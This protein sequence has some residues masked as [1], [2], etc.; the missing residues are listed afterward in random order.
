MSGEDIEAPADMPTSREAADAWLRRRA[1]GMVHAHLT[2]REEADFAR[3]VKSMIDHTVHEYGGRFLF[4]LIQNGYDEQ[5]PDRTDG[6][7]SFILDEDELDHGVLYAANTGKGFTTSNVRAIANLGLSDKEIGQGIG[8]KGVGFKSVLQVCGAPEIYSTLPDGA[9]GFCFRFAQPGDIPGLVDD[10]P[11]SI[12]QVLEEMSLYNITVPSEHTPDFVSELWRLG[13]ASVIRL[14]LRQNTREMVA[15]LLD[16]EISGSNVPVL[17]FLRRLAQITVQKKRQGS[18][19]TVVLTRETESVPDLQDGPSCELVSLRGDERYLVFTS[20]VPPDAFAAAVHVSVESN[21]LDSRWEKS[22]SGVEVSIGVPYGAPAAATGRFFT[23]LPLG[24][25]APSPFG[26]H[27]N[28]PFSTNLARTDIDDA[29]PLNHL[30]LSA[31]AELCVDAAAALTAWPECQPESVLDIVCWDSKRVAFLK[32]QAEAKGEPLIERHF[33]PARSPRHWISFNEAWRWPS[34]E[35]SV[36]TASRATKV[37]K[38]DFLP[39]LEPGRARR[40]KDLLEALGHSPDPSGVQLA[41][42]TEAM[43]EDMRAKKRPIA[44]WD[45]AY[46]DI[47]LLFDGQ[48]GT[49]RSRRILLTD[50]GELRPCASSGRAPDNVTSREATPFFP[51][52]RQPVDEEENFDPEVDLDLPKSLQN[53]LFYLHSGLTW[54]VNRQRT[55]ARNFFQVNRLIR[56]FDTRSILEHVRGL[57]AGSRSKAVSR[58]AIRLVFNLSRSAPSNMNLA[59]LGLRVPTLGGRWIPAS[60]ALFSAGWPGTRGEELALIANTPAD[61][62]IELSALTNRLIATPSELPGSADN[63]SAWVDFLKRIGVGDVLPLIEHREARTLYGRSL[64]ASSLSHVPGMP[65]GVAEQWSGQLPTRSNAFYPETPYKQMTSLFWLPGQAD[66]DHLTGKVRQA[67]CRQIL[68]G[69]KEW[70]DE[71]FLTTWERD[72]TG[73][74]DPR[75]FVT[76]LQAFL[77]TAPWLMVQRP[78]ETHEAFATPAESWTFPIRGEETPPRFATL[79]TK[80]LRDLLDD[81]SRAIRRLRQLGVGVWGVRE[82]APRLVRH[83]GQLVASEEVPDLYVAQFRNMYQRAWA[84]CITVSDPRPFPDDKASWLVVE[85]G[86]TTTALTIPP[87]GEDAEPHDLVVASTD[88]ER[89]LLRLLADFK[90]P[91]LIVTSGA[92]QVTAFLKKRIG[93]QVRRATDIAPIVLVD[94]FL[95]DGKAANDDA[96][97][98]VEVMPKL[99]LL[100]ATLLEFRRGSFSHLGQRAFED[101]LDALRRVRLVFATKIEVSIGDH[102][103]SLPAR[104]QG[105]LSVPDATFP[106]L[107]VAKSGR[108]L[109][110]TTLDALAEALMHLIGRPEIATELRLAITRMQSGAVPLDDISHDDVAN[111]CEISLDDVHTTARRIEASVTPLLERLYPFVTLFAGHEAASSF[112][113]ESSVLTGESDIG[114]GLGLVAKQLPI[115]SAELLKIALDSSSVNELRLRLNVPLERLNTT[116]RTLGRRYPPIDYTKQLAE[117]FADHVRSHHDRILDRI[118]W[119]RRDWFQA[120]RPQTDWT[121]LRDPATITPDPTWGWTRDFLSPEE[122]DERVEIELQRLLGDAPPLTGSPLTPRGACAEANSRMISTLI[123]GLTET[124]RA[125][126][127]VRGRPVRWPWIDPETALQAA[128]ESL[129]RAGALDF[130]K[131][132]REELLRWLNALDFWP[133][134]MP[135]SVDLAS[136][137]LSASNLKAQRTEEAKRRADDARIRRTVLIDN[138][139]FDLENGHNALLEAIERSLEATPGVISARNR[140]T[141]LKEVSQQASSRGG[142]GDQTSSAGGS[143]ARLSDQQRDAIGFAGEW[144]A[145]KWLNRLH[146]EAFSPECWV[147]KYRERVF[148]GQGDDGLGCDFQ[149]STRQG[150]LLYEVKTSQGEGGQFELGETQVLAAQANA[151]NGLWRLLV[152][153]DVLNHNRK[154]RMLRNPFDPKARGQYVFV[155][156]GLRLRYALE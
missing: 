79:V 146:K 23:Y 99:P 117:D 126:L 103:R 138:Q 40:L 5:D 61:R 86:G 3:S 68:H 42:W 89:S 80:R 143:P 111:A 63:T 131:L 7:L 29:N 152:I 55:P 28:A 36:L 149:V 108:H 101:G 48:A 128:F 97:L 134:D 31:A 137:G 64:V 16:Q 54:Y 112:D 15:A 96:A 85:V 21:Q 10:D 118:R 34:P 139:A 83:L 59:D 8:N 70:E 136:L 153:T 51:A 109:E 151:R 71:V 37:C 26:G 124:V 120:F 9:P 30:L 72:R 129:D 142:P 22:N 13:F 74:R 62:S 35:T 56:G 114:H 50:G 52:A 100:V 102:T 82:D 94:G 104:S 116:L 81:D 53:R 67:L 141:Q 119:S 155:G 88:D 110:W 95:F 147:S 133:A 76:P 73:Y 19:T 78:G 66:W 14:P 12:Q 92:E 91:V 60:E 84:D 144:L 33:V 49:L 121:V 2:T 130:I 47:A 87:L 135:L 77:A 127:T 18:I 39:D 45:Q 154:I 41:T 140:Y 93:E 32:D 123:S 69:M 145:Y 65:A 106:T 113:P 46:A 90:R 125:W 150:P 11:T 24:E 58:D 75:P 57:L 98:L 4:E 25:K 6:R 156:Q 1:Q 38:V 107:V 148:P 105:V 115:G 44:E 17:L 43:L 122:M 20:P 132:D 27:L